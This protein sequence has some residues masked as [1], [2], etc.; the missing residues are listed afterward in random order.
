MYPYFAQWIRSHRDLPLRLNQWTNIVRWEFK[1]PTPFIRSREFLWQEGHTAFATET[2]AV[3]EVYT[4]LDLYRRVYEELLAIPVIRGFKSEAEKFAGAQFTT[5]VEAFIPST[6]RGIQGGTSHCLG[7]NFSKIFNIT[8]PHTP[9]PFRV[10]WWFRFSSEDSES[11]FVWQ[12]SWGL[13][14]RTIGVMVMIHGDDRGVV[15]PPKVTSWQIVVIP[16][17]N[18]KLK[19]EEKEALLKQADALHKDL[20]AAGIR[21]T[22]DFRENYTPGWKYN[23]WELKGVPIRLELGPRDMEKEAC[24]LVRRDTLTKTFDVKWTEL[25]DRVADLLDS[26]QADMFAKAKAKMEDCIEVARTWEEFME[27]LNRRHMVLAPW[28]NE[29]EVEEKV[30]KD[31]AVGDQMGAKT[32]CMPFKDDPMVP[33]LEDDTLCFVTGKPAVNWTLWGRSY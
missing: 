13:T 16:I 27:V 4:I 5:S 15:V 19:A 28:C 1:H 3:D 23:H 17:L 8:Y 2:E 12:N 32:L 33:P 26:I 6:G 24:V 9:L 30:K 18:V 21:A 7:Q 14:T 20:T 11:Q 31:S 22:K 10:L 25:T 29:T